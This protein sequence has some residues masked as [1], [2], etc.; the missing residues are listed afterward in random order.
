MGKKT[1]GEVCEGHE[2]HLQ[3]NKA[4]HSIVGRASSET[5]QVSFPLPVR[6]IQD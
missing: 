4:H 6:R 1:G 3:Q 5:Q 2:R